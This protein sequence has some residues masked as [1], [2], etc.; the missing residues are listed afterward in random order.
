MI[1]QLVN[2]FL[3]FK[4]RLLL[5]WG[6]LL[7]IAL[8][9]GFSVIASFTSLKPTDPIWA[10]LVYI[11]LFGLLSLLSWQR[12]RQLHVNPQH[13]IGQWQ[14][15]NWFGIVGLVIALMLFSLGAFQLSVFGL[16]FLNPEL[17]NNI[18]QQ[19]L[20]DAAPESAA[21][22]AFT[23]LNGV[24]IVLVAPIAEEF[25]FRGILLQRWAVKWNLQVA[26]VASSVLFGMLHLNVVGLSMFGFVMGLLYIRTRS[27]FVPIVYHALNNALAL[28]MGLFANQSNSET[29]LTE[30]EKFVTDWWVG[31]LMMAVS[32][33]WLIR[34]ILKNFPRQDA[35]IPYLTNLT[36]SAEQES[37]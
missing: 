19:T 3:V 17:V 16:S 14:P 5:L 24:S 33:P 9:A 34:F 25:I 10:T 36:Q 27:L 26:L 23:V 7:S 8:S 13:I 18:L 28:S 21:P 22:V 37:E 2:P 4:V 29:S 31:A 1:P 32:A 30:L 15:P 35:P 6:L 11:G 20:A 12:L